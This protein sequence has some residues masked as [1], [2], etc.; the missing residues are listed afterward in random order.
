MS[1]NRGKFSE[2]NAYRRMPCGDLCLKRC[3]FL[4]CLCRCP[5]KGAAH[6]HAH[7]QSCRQNETEQETRQLGCLLSDLAIL[8]QVKELFWSMPHAIRIRVAVSRCCGVAAL[9]AAPDC[10][11]LNKFHNN[12]RRPN[13]HLTKFPVS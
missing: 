7:T 12:S 1:L 5:V 9:T 13:K 8:E 2:L 6:T 3:R 10:W 4:C 11:Q